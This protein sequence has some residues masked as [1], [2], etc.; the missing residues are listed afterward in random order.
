MSDIL[1]L[2]AARKASVQANLATAPMETLKEEKAPEAEAPQGGY[3]ALRL[4]RFAKGNGELVVAV[5]G[6][7]VP[8]DEEEYDMLEYYVTHG[9]LVEAPAKN[10]KL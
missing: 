7:F 3:K 2:A 10:K 1:K 8:K 4:T 9:M 5:D 6:Y